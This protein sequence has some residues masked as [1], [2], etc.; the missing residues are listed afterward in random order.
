M[1]NI[2]KLS[3]GYRPEKKLFHNLDLQ[4]KTGSIYGLLGKNGAGKTTLL[5][6]ICGLLFPQEGAC[7]IKGFPAQERNPE[8]L[9]DIFL[10]AEEFY[11]PALTINMYE[12]IYAPFYPGFNHEKFAENLKEFEL[13]TNATLTTLSY[14]QKKK[15][16]LAFG[17]ATACN[18]FILDEPS[19]GLDIPSKRQL[20]RLLAASLEPHRMFIISTHQ[21]R[22]LENIIDPI[23]IL[24]EGKIILNNSIQEIS[25]RLS[26][27]LE[28]NEPT[29]DQT[30]LYSE[31]TMGGYATLRENQL[32]DESQIDIE[33][34]FNAVIANRGKMQEI[35]RKELSY[36]A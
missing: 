9:H 14:G 17:L 16:L 19:N 7:T 28:P 32:K 27:S 11:L 35:L 24:D 25:S 33:L 13:N 15:F 1:I 20:R 21:V 36:E 4:F 29:T 2:E 23:I 5:K 12:K 30:I 8:F 22:D 31:K 26:M 3:F 6:L 18:C 10:I 34:L